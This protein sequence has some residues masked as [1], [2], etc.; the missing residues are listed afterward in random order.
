MIL[1]AKTWS[2]YD[3][4]AANTSMLPHG[5]AK[6]ILTERFKM[7]TCN[8]LGSDSVLQGAFI[9]GSPTKVVLLRNM[10]GPGSVDEDLEDEV[11]FTLSTFGRTVVSQRF[12]TV[13]C[14]QLPLA[15]LQ[16]IPGGLQRD[17]ACVQ[18][19]QSSWSRR[20]NF[21]FTLI[22]PLTLL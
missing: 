1:P 12:A 15:G 6:R 18:V 20:H 2:H 11:G 21:A 22:L 10:V 17:P 19:E 14:R 7:T 8:E 5:G 16:D 13:L 3:H 9:S 4:D